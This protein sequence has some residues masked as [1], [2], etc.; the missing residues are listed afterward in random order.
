[1]IRPRHLQMAGRY[2]A[3]RFRAL[4]PY[5]VEINLLNACNLRC[6]YCR[7]PEVKM[8]LLTTEQWCDV[9]R[10]LGEVG[11]LRVRFQGGEPTLRH[12]F[13]E[14]CAEVQR[15][16]A[17]C[18]VTTNGT[19]IAD[20]PA[21]LDHL[22]EAVFSVDALTPEVHDRLRGAGTH[23][24][25][26]RAIGLA[27]ERKVRA[28]VTM[29]VNKTNVDEIEPLL[30]F[31][32]AR[33]IGMH[34][35][36]VIFGHPYFDDAARPLALTGEQERTVHEQLARWKRAGRGLMFTAETYAGVARWPDHDVLA[37]RDESGPS[38]CMAGKY[39]IHIE[40]NGD[41]HPC[42][43]HHST[44]VPKNLVRDGFEAALL[45]VQRH[46]CVDCFTACLVERKAVF[47]MRP[48]ALLE[49]LRR[50]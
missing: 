7:C 29:V 36:P 15:A 32:E 31:C 42:V 38:P 46:D 6:V 43:M 16:G 48:A 3:H 8:A 27:L 22:D 40:A 39:H 9:I 11:T 13:R 33:G 10:R 35:Q 20:R 14:L 37:V 25:V 49:V 17:A 5:D 18:G 41:V 2:L 50:D 34:A 4:H 12:D 21:L 47:G 44:I 30:A 24:Q 1:M 26:M 23:A 45:H 28:Y 19:Q